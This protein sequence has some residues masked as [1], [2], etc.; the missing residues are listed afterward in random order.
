MKRALSALIAVIII[1]SSFSVMGFAQSD[2]KDIPWIIIHGMNGYGENSEKYESKPYWGKDDDM[3]TYLRADGYKVYAP[4]IGPMSSSWDRACELFAQLTGTVV[5]YGEAHSE[6]Y[7][8][9]R[10]GRD[11]TG[12]ATMGTPWDVE[13]PLNLIAHSLGG[14][15]ARIF[16]SLLAYGNEDEIA[17]GSDDISPLFTGGHDKVINALV[18]ISA[19][20]NGTQLADAGLAT[21]L[22]PPAVM[23]VAMVVPSMVNDFFMLEHWNIVGKS[24]IPNLANVLKFAKADNAADDITMKGAAEITKNYKLPKDIL[25]ITYAAD[26]TGESFTGHRVGLPADGVYTLT[27]EMIS[28]AANFSYDGVVPGKDWEANDGLVPVISAQY[29]FNDEMGHVFYT[30]G[31]AM[32]R[33][34]WNVM[35]TLKGTHSYYTGAIG[36]IEDLTAYFEG[37][38]DLANAQK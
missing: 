36:T 20:H 18:T 8:H 3:L 30:D 2:N 33:G 14:P 38:F 11:Y 17:T 21:G 24:G 34:V 4:T 5:D 23:L 37:V 16:I 27:S 10:Y 28:I 35:P 32:K 13:S 29:P 6:K 26:T 19:P 15:T 7:G 25:Y 1:L 22:V 12:K 9:N 31:M